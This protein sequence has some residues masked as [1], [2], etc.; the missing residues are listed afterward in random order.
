MIEIV[1][2]DGEYLL[3]VGRV[4]VGRVCHTAGT[5]AARIDADAARGLLP[6]WMPDTTRATSMDR[7]RRKLQARWSRDPGRKDY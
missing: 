7:L 4:Y 6:P 1:A 5:W 2:R 3:R